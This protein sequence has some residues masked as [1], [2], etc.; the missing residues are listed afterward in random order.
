[1]ARIGARELVPRDGID[2]VVASYDA[3]ETIGLEPELDLRVAQEDQRLYPRRAD[4]I[5]QRAF[6]PR[7]EDL[8]LALGQPARI[9]APQATAFGRDPD[10]VD[11]VTLD[12]PRVRLELHH[13][14]AR[15][16]KDH[17]VELVLAPGR[18]IQQID[19]RPEMVRVGV[20]QPL[21]RELDAVAL[22]R[23]RRLTDGDDAGLRERHG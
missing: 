6:E 15:V 23:I 16:T 3:C 14:Q 2:E 11:R 17:Q 8:R 18:W 13:I 21:L 4:P 19:Q 22:V 5:R 9:V 1:M 10:P 20:G 12:E 7:L